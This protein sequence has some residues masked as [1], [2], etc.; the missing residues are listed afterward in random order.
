MNN[1][2]Q[3]KILYGEK[4]VKI[5]DSLKKFPGLS[6]NS[7]AK[8]YGIEGKKEK[9]YFDLYRPIGYQPTRAEIDYCIQDSKIIAYA[10]K[11]ELAQ[12]H[13]LMTLSSDAFN[14]VKNTIG[15]FKGWRKWFPELSDFYEQ[16]TRSSYK[17]GF[18]Y[19]NPR[20]QNKL[21]RDV[22]VYDV[23]SL[24]PYVMHDCVLPYGKPT[25]RKPFGNELYVVKFDAEFRLKDGYLPTVQ[26][27]HNR[28]YDGT[29]YLTESKGVIEDLHMTSIDY[30]LFE[31]HYDISYMSEPEYICFNGKVGLLAPYIDKWMKVKEEAV[32]QG[33]QDLKFIAKRWLNSPYGKTG[34][35]PNRIN[36][37]PMMREDGELVFGE[38]EEKA[39]PVYVPY[40]SFVCAQ[41]R[42]IT[43][44]S[45]QKEFDNF[46]YADTDSLHL[47]GT[48]HD[49][50]DVHP[51]HLGKW[52]NE[53]TYELAKYLR[54]KTYIHGH[55]KSV[56][57]YLNEIIVDEIKCAGM[58]DTIKET[59]QW[60]DF[61]LGKDFGE[62]KLLQCSCKGG[63]YL[64]PTRYRIQSL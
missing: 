12:G 10:M 3:I 43:I 7:I 20:Y 21:L 51:S 50:L 64:R 39:D 59:V 36:R 33:R 5:W 46:V 29:E 31:E 61:R 54:A 6:V 42:N 48:E 60:E 37:I 30:K 26:I 57:E 8:L 55:F 24:Y 40:A 1:W 22:T 9:P 35:N 47:L 45:A 15:G 16:F 4:V 38:Q 32:Q 14:D 53:G 41:A 23:N 28:F 18:V 2:Y 62:S 63:C 25:M 49:E 27:K 44:R 58:T 13:K 11:Q 19:V 17:G 52:K 56:N 34:M